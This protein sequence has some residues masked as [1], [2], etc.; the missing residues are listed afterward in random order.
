MQQISRAQ[1]VLILRRGISPTVQQMGLYNKTGGLAAPPVFYLFYLCFFS[2]L[3]IFVIYLLK[4]DSTELPL[5]EYR[6][7]YFQA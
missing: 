1:T 3:F 7:S 5:T 2:I 4:S 6:Q